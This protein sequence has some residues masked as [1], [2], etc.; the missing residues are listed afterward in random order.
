[1]QII[2][3][4]PDFAA[5]AN[6]ESPAGFTTP[7]QVGFFV[8][9]WFHYLHNV[10]T[11]LGLATFSSLVTI[12]SN[13]RGTFGDDGWSHAERYLRQASHARDIERQYA[14]MDAMRGF[15]RS[16][17]SKIVD[18]SA[19]RVLSVNSVPADPERPQE[20]QFLACE[21]EVVQDAKNPLSVDG[22]K[23]LVS[24]STH[25][26]VECAAIMLEERVALALR[27]VMP[28][29]SVDPYRMI[30][31]I[32]RFV[33]P[34]LSDDHVLMVALAALQHPN[35]PAAL[36]EIL[37]SA[38]NVAVK[39]NDPEVYIRGTAEALIKH[40]ASSS[41]ESLQLLENM[42]PLDEPMGR[43]IK[44]TVERIRRNMGYRQEDAFFELGIVEDLRKNIASM[45][46]M[47]RR[48]GAPTLIQ[49]RKGDKHKIERDLMYWI[50]VDN[51]SED[52]S[53]GWRWMN[54]AFRFVG[55]HLSSG[56]LRPTAEAALSEC[57]FY[58]VCGVDY[59][60]S[61]PENC[62]QRPWISV[63]AEGNLCDYAVAVSLTRP[64][65]RDFSSV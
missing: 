39:G 54:A 38:E 61:N 10:S 4:K 27:A 5:F 23:V 8:H 44:L 48:Y 46:G 31:K 35:S 11:T 1:M 57:P 52:L 43:A 6:P 32:A 13:F 3:L 7:E 34:N 26:I 49:Q 59:R 51:E 50:K 18:Q 60:K 21:I 64:V 12:W 19:V 2:V 62:R 37:R 41:E 47:L 42:F 25:H 65:P 24:V 30:Q 20:L 56:Q 14:Q 40:A 17:L 53:D 29:P 58:T 16:E 15:K 9:E 36:I 55:A 33:A 22:M 45:D 28:A 63:E